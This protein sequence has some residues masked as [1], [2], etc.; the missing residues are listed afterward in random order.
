VIINH[1]LNID[2]NNRDYHFGPNRAALIWIKP[3]RPALK[4][5]INGMQDSFLQRDKK[6]TT[7]E[8]DQYSF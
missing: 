4:Q 5:H 8:Q 2:Q 1:D 3:G 6:T 7:V